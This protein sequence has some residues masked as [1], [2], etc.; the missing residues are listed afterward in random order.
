[1]ANN[2]L[3][4]KF[5]Q[6]KDK[7]H[8]SDITQS[9]LFE[10]EKICSQS[11]ETKRKET[12]KFFLTNIDSSLLSYKS[13]I[14]LTIRAF[15]FATSMHYSGK[16]ADIGEDEDSILLFAQSVYRRFIEQYAK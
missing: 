5:Y 9:Y 4:Y 12:I 2:T 10:S 6:G 3:T 14:D 15:I 7:N 1:M 16:N 13:E 11:D 8:Y